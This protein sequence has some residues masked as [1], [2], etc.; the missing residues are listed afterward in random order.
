MFVNAPEALSDARRD[1]LQIWLQ[2]RQ[3]GRE[4]VAA[5]RTIAAAIAELDGGI[6]ADRIAEATAIR[7]WLQSFEP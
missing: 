5:G 3:Y 4:G 7:N 2:N 6:E 1:Q